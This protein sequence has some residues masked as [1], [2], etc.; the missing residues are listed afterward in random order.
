MFRTPKRRSKLMFDVFTLAVAII[1]FYWAVNNFGLITWWIGWF[2]GVLSPFIAGGV[3]AYFLSIPVAGIERLF[4][5][6]NHRFVQ[7]RKRHI[8][9]IIVYILLAALI[10]GILQ[11]VLPPLISAISDLVNSLPAFL[12]TAFEFVEE[13]DSEEVIVPLGMNLNEIIEMVT[14]FI[15]EDMFLLEDII[16]VLQA[17]IGAVI[18]GAAAIFDLFLAIISSIYFMFE[19]SKLTAFARRV[20]YRFM[21][22]ENADMVMGYAKK[23]DGYFR[24]YIFCVLIDCLA[25]AA[26]APVVLYLLGSPFALLLGL[27]LGIF[28]AIPF[29]GSIFA[30]VIAVVVTIFDQGFTMGM[31]TLVV[32]LVLQQLDGNVFQPWLYGG[33]L[34]LNPLLVIVS[35][36][37]GGAIGGMVTGGMWGTIVGMFVAI[38]I[39]KV[40]ANI[41]E[42]ILNYEKPGD[43]LVNEKQLRLTDKEH[44]A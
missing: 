12:Q 4:S 2:F 25:M 16:N 8:S 17:H 32:L 24:K 21:G 34:K 13:L 38:P 20:M 42:D 37:V 39:T 41:T 19:A 30:V 5:K 7:K 6:I 9:V 14:S 33:G 36:I 40:L 10:Y 1:L 18:G 29:F 31:I 26:V 15:P 27:L 43:D 28:N 22:K 11:I 35:I 3:V 23:T 44:R